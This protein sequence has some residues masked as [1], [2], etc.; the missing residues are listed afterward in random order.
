[1]IASVRQV[2]E[3][4]ASEFK[5]PV[6]HLFQIYISTGS[7]TFFIRDKK[8]SIWGIFLSDNSYFA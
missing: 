6:R 3:V 8:A 7:S 1:M 4:S 2:R 5:T